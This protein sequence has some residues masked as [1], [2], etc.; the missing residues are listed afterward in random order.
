VALLLPAL[1]IQR[2]HSDET[3]GLT[4]F[5]LPSETVP[6]P[7]LPGLSEAE[8][9]ARRL[10]NLATEVGEPTI[11]KVADG[12]AAEAYRFFYAPAFNSD[13][14]V[15]A[16]REGNLFRMRT[17]VLRWYPAPSSLWG[18][19]ETISVRKWSRLQAAFAKHSVTDPLDGTNPYGG[20]DG[21]SWYMQSSVS[22][23]VTITQISS[24]IHTFGPSHF[25]IIRAKDPRLADFLKTSFLFLDWAGVHVPEMY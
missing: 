21:S 17:V 23:R 20:I 6:L 15:T 4:Y 5:G 3:T 22:G 8:Y 11:D 12:P 24:P 2:L 13:V 19:T 7:T 18:K 10:A 16:W 14:C 1:G 9:T 25:Q